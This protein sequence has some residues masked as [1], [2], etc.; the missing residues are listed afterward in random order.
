MKLIDAEQQIINTVLDISSKH[1]IMKSVDPEHIRDIINFFLE[2]Q[3]KENQ[4]K[5]KRFIDEKIE[6]M[7]KDIIDKDIKGD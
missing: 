1:D 4:S 6:Q 7:A 2:N 3:F 5:T